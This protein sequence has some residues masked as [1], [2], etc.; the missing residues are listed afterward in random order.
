MGSISYRIPYGSS[1]KKEVAKYVREALPGSEVVASNFAPGDYGGGKWG[2]WGGYYYAA[3][4]MPDG[5]VWASITAFQQYQGDVVIKLMDETMGPTAIGV[6]AKVLAALT[7]LP[8]DAHEWQRG[9]REE[10][11]QYQ[12]KRKAALAAKGKT[13]KLAKPVKLTSGYEIDEVTVESMKL[14]RSGG[15]RIRP[16]HDWFLREWEVAA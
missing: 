11:Q 13:I 7:P 16:G 15:L 4:K 12:A 3:H 5:T 14:W 9:W 10:A 8:E 1:A 6:G 2:G